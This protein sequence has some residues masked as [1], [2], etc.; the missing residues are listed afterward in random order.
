MYTHNTLND[1]E[2]PKKYAKLVKS[3]GSKTKSLRNGIAVEVKM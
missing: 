1:F 2:E 3:T